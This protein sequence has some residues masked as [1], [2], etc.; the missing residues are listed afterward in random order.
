LRPPEVVDISCHRTAAL[1]SQRH[2]AIPRQAHDE[3]WRDIPHDK[4]NQGWYLGPTAFYVLRPIHR[5]SP[6]PK[7]RGRYGRTL[8]RRNSQPPRTQTFASTDGLWP[9]QETVIHDKVPGGG[10]PTGS[11]CPPPGSAMPPWSFL[12]MT[13]PIKTS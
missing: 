7:F 3:E 4:D 13:D 2:P 5:R 11:T 12:L 9:V 8:G 6:V 10:N 1:F